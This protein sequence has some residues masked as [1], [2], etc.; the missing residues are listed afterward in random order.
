MEDYRYRYSFSLDAVPPFVNQLI[1]QVLLKR[2][3]VEY[4]LLNDISIGLNLLIYDVPVG[5]I[6]GVAMIA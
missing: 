2:T 1:K 3:G 5:R 6:L 4:V